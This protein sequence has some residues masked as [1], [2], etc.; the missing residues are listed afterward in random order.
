MFF[1]SLSPIS[2][3][4]PLKSRPWATESR[5]PPTMEVFHVSLSPSSLSK[6]LPKASAALV[7]APR[8]FSCRSKCPTCSF[9]IANWSL[10]TSSLFCA[11]SKTRLRIL[12]SFDKSSRFCSLA[13]LVSSRTALN[14]TCS[15]TFF[16]RP[17]TWFLINSSMSL[18][19]SC[20]FLR[21]AGSSPSVA[22]AK[23]GIN[24]AATIIN[25]RFNSR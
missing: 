8:A 1:L 3:R 17:S 25:A 14:L 20:C 19:S 16:L 4:V 18:K 9:K 6:D 7:E 2:S 22:N 21:A 23:T 13:V 12:N 15:A 5:S 24:P 10:S 11:S